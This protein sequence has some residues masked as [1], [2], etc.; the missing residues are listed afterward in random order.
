MVEGDD[1][2]HRARLAAWQDEL[3][4][5]HQRVASRCC[6]R[7]VRE[8][9]GRERSGLLGPVERPHGWLLAAPLGERTPDRL[10][11]LL[12]TA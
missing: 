11:R 3:A 12:R 6:Q 8:R 4:A 10:P 5:P 9:I 1:T 2:R 7:A